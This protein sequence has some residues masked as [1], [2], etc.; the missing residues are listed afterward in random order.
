MPLE[1]LYFFSSE[2]SHFTILMIFQFFN[3]QFSFFLPAT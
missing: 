1:L 3:F 2:I